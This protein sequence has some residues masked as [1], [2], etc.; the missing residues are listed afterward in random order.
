MVPHPLIHLKLARI[1]CDELLTTRHRHSR[2][3]PD[4]IRDE[5][6]R[7]GGRRGASA[8]RACAL[9]AG[10]LVGCA[11]CPRPS[12]ETHFAHREAN[13]ITVDLY[14]THGEHDDWFRVEVVDHHDDRTFTLFPATGKEAVE[15]YHHPFATT[16]RGRGFDVAA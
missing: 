4:A 7:G 2:I 1:R 10:R 8:R 16:A 9:L 13:G 12:V 3:D 15:V 11:R 5:P 6:R 14:W